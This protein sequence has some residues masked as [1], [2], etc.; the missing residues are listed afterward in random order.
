MNQPTAPAM[1]SRDERHLKII[2][3]ASEIFIRYGFA[4]TNMGDIAAA[5]SISRPTLYQHFSQKQDV[6]GAVIEHLAEQ[7]LASLQAELPRKRSLSSKLRHACLSWSLPGFDLTRANPDAKDLFDP[8]FAPVR[9]AHAAF[10]QLLAG[11]LADAGRKQPEL[12]AEMLA[13]ALK[14]LKAQAYDREHLAAMINRLCDI[15]SAT[16]A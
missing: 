11:V 1:S 8:G 5:A 16:S 9:N 15:V 3:A 4:R 6:F 14:G 12:S 2:Q 7:I 10:V 13:A